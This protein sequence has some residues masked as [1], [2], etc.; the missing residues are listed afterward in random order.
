MSARPRHLLATAALLAAGL[1][2]TALVAGPAAAADGGRPLSTGLTG[3]AEFPGP[4]DTDGSGAAAL[5]VNPGTGEVCYDLAVQN[6]EPATMAH[7]HRGAAGAAG[8]VVVGLDPPT[9]GTSAGCAAVDRALAR[10]ILRDPAAY[11]VNV[12][13]A[14]FRS[15]AVRGQLS[16]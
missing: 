12:H 5:R 15:G 9:D 2:G 14:A 13:N 10:E 16:R 4:G 1:G 6:I 8:P 11:Y 7:I 3:S